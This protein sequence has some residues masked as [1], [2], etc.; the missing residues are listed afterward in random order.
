MLKENKNVS[1]VPDEGPRRWFFDE[2]FDL[3]VWYDQAGKKVEGFQLCYDKKGNERALTWRKSGSID[4]TKVDVGEDPF[5]AKMTPI[6]VAD[7]AFETSRI[8]EKFQ[9]AADLLEENLRDLVAD[10]IKTYG[11]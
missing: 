1:Q 10:V 6:L 5:R 7:G 2:F 11:P 8:F 9:A 4:H 3:I